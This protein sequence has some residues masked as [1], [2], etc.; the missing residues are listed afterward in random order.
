MMIPNDPAAPAG[1]VLT[2]DPSDQKWE[3]RPRPAGKHA[4]SLIGWIRERPAVDAGVPDAVARVFARTL[5]HL[6]N[7]TFLHDGARA[8]NDSPEWHVTPEGW[9]C[10]LTPPGWI[11]RLV[12]PRWPLICTARPET[13]LE[14]FDADGF[15]W[16][17]LAQVA[18]VNPARDA[19]PKLTYRQVT[20]LLDRSE[21]E[22]EP[23]HGLTIF[24]P[25]VDGDFA[26][27]IVFDPLHW[28]EVETRLHEECVRSGLSFK[29]VSETEFNRTKWFC[30][31]DDE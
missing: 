20:D 19:P 26:E 17:L 24:S 10:T 13:S 7:V 14:L 23:L 8:L 5:C 3:I 28:E 16:E 12:A 2:R 29:V 25:A 22:G 31:M 4:R 30:H 6:G 15:S 27:I 21:H 9:A 11:R 18:N 1:M